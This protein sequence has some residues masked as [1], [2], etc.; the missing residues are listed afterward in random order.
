MM[1]R[2]TGRRGFPWRLSFLM[3]L[4]CGPA[5]WGAVAFFVATNRNAP[6][7]P[8][9]RDLDI[10]FQAAS[11]TG[12]AEIDRRQYSTGYISEPSTLRAGDVCVTP[13]V[14]DAQGK[15]AADLATNGRRLIETYTGVPGFRLGKLGVGLLTDAGHRN[16][17]TL[18][19]RRGSPRHFVSLTERPDLNLV[20]TSTQGD[21]EAGRHYVEMNFG[22]LQVPGGRLPPVALPPPGGMEGVPGRYPR[23]E[24]QSRAV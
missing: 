17:W 7:Q 4:A 10:S 6:T 1:D 3:M 5:A 9:N 19:N 22:E 20:V 11:G 21:R 16:L 8:A 13:N 15:R 23:R 12:F 14:L 2:E 18:A 24:S